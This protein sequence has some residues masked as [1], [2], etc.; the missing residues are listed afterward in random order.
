[1]VGR[2]WESDLGLDETGVKAKEEKSHRADVEHQNHSHWYFD[3]MKAIELAIFT[4]PPV[5]LCPPPAT[6][7][8]VI[9]IDCNMRAGFKTKAA[10]NPFKIYLGKT[11]IIN[12][13]LLDPLQLS[14][15]QELP[16]YK[17]IKTEDDD[18]TENNHHHSNVPNNW[19]MEM[20]YRTMQCFII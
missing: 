5:S 13:L 17:W 11:R 4:F 14:P 6:I 18:D 10:S 1:M 9:L 19:G 2:V 15:P 8:K 20:G 12:S 7:K 16:R 3:Q